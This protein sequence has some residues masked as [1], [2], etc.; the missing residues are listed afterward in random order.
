MADSKIVI[1]SDIDFEPVGF[2][3][4]G[5]D[6]NTKLMWFLDDKT[7]GSTKN[8]ETLEYRVPMGEHIL[9]TVDTTGAATEIKFSVV[10][11]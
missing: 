10:G 5:A 3:A 11:G 2:M 7:L 8:G 4:F 6:Q 9:R 1:T